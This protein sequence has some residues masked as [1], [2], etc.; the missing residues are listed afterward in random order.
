MSQSARRPVLLHVLPCLPTSQPIPTCN[1]ATCTEP[2][3]LLFVSRQAAIGTV[4]IAPMALIDEA[5]GPPTCEAWKTVETVDGKTL[6]GSA[7]M[8]SSCHVEDRPATVIAKPICIDGPLCQF[9]NF[10]GVEPELESVM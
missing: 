1:A 8:T 3:V 10:Q 5:A 4:E 6:V 2:P 9:V 7:S